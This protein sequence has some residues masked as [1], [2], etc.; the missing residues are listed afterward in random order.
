M[1]SKLLVGIQF[2]LI[3]AIVLYCK[4]P[5]FQWSSAVLF[6][7]GGFIGI[8]ALISM[9]IGNIRIQPIPKNNAKLITTGIYKTIR[10][11]MY[12][13][14]ILMMASF[15][16]LKINFISITIFL[17]L[18]ITLFLKMFYEERLLEEKFPE[19]SAYKKQTRRLI[20]F[21]F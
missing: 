1:Y 13:S 12:S 5:S 3:S 15:V 9:Q 18:V 14:V 8:W 7:L 6:L 10:H 17:L 21:I 4:I 16:I 20:P 11:P 2:S 19:Y